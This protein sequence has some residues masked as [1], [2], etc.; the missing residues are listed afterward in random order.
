[1]TSL[2][3]HVHV[4]TDVYNFACI[5]PHKKF[6]TQDNFFEWCTIAETD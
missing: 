5:T 4:F 6:M 3:E 1:L 2:R